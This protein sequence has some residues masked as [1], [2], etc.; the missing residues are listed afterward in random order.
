[1]AAPQ[2]EVSREDWSARRSVVSD[3]PDTELRPSWSVSDRF[4]PRTVLRPLQDFLSTSTA[5]A[6]LLLIAAVVALV[7][8]NSPF[9][10]SYDSL[11]HT[12]IGLGVGSWSIELDLQ[13]WVN[14]ALMALFFLVVGLEIKRE[15][16]QGEL[17][18]PKAAALPAIAAIG[19]M[20][21]PALLYVA[22]NAGGA[23]ASGWGIP[24][25]TDI[26]FALGVLTLA[27]RHAPA[28]IK[29]FVLTLAIVDDIGAIL[30][31]AL[32]YS[33]GVSTTPLLVAAGVIATIVVLQRIGVRANTAYVVLA[34]A[35][36]LATFEA[37]IHPTIAGVVMGLL[38]PMYPFQPP[39]AV[40][41][42][43]IRTA[44]ETDDDPNEPDAGAHLWL[45][46]ATLSK[47]A[48]SPLVRIEH[49]LL[50][51]TS[52]VIVPI[53]ALANAGVDLSAESL[54]DALTS[55]VTLGVIVGLVVGKTVGIWAASLLAVRVGVAR[56]P[57]GVD[58]RHVLGAGA[59]AGI[60]FTVA[61]FITE[62]AFDDA[63]LRDEAKIGILIAS[64]LAGL[65]GWFLLRLAPT[66]SGVPDDLV[67]R[68]T[69][70]EGAPDDQS[71]G[72]P[73]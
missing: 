69:A 45:R 73:R 22:L 16:L 3:R 54:G 56:L 58:L 43:A 36:W 65:L 21:V 47:E 50:P 35:L 60:G 71:F 57:A 19:G 24:M 14:D 23:G 38:T 1:M 63:A 20:A 72:D 28:A 67:E 34:I 17:R 8:A 32:F 11:W 5:S 40:S 7:W 9:G 61:L 29:P 41:R 44:D 68:T 25:A 64:V 33:G 51:W 46:L 70:S 59:V 30:V 18:D 53:F 55:R 15:V 12:E 31:I 10:E 13:H 4:L 48:V 27:A 26:A 37:G 42:E 52:F 66:A 6:F 2:H 62:L 39:A 49:A